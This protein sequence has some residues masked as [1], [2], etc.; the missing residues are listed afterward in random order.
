MDTEGDQRQ[1]AP[2]SLRVQGCGQRPLVHH[3]TVNQMKTGNR[4]RLQCPKSTQ[5]LGETS[6]MRVA[7][8]VH[9]APGKLPGCKEREK[10][11]PARKKGRENPS[12]SLHN[13][14]M[15]K[16]QKPDF[17]PDETGVDGYPGPRRCR[18][19]INRVRKGIHPFEWRNGE[20]GHLPATGRVA[21]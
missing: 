14:R 7:D 3:R 20:S 15:L 16:R 21:V 10:P 1:K 4:K 8:K 9:S 13:Q 17:P 2:E 19:R 6:Q 12:R 11:F 5:D 18:H